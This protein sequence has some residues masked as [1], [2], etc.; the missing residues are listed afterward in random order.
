MVEGARATI[1]QAI[2]QYNANVAQYRQTVLAAF[3]QV[4]DYLAQTRILTTAVEQQCAAVALAEKAFEL[5]T[6]RY[7]KGLDPYL[8]VM[9]QQTLLA[10]C[11]AD[12]RRAARSAHLGRRAPGSGTR[13]RL[14]PLAVA[15]P[16]PGHGASSRARASDRTVT[17]I[18]D[19]LRNGGCGSSGWHYD[20]LTRSS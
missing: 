2:A 7:E 12:A 3:Q 8:N 15:E 19:A 20:V 4:E 18:G 6:F 11:A 17:G 5:A 13:R 10:R 1:D 9:T 14:G 16:G